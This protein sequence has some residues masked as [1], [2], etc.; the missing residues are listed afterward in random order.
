MAFRSDRDREHQAAHDDGA[1]LRR[2]RST[3]GR[4]R[5]LRRRRAT[6]RGRQRPL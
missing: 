1:P 6:R 2:R 5:D 4:A 3:A